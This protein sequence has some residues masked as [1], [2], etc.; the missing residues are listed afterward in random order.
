MSL[1]LVLKCDECAPWLIGRVS[2]I[3]ELIISLWEVVLSCMKTSCRYLALKTLELS[4]CQGQDHY[5]QC[6][7]MTRQQLCNK[8]VSSCLPSEQ[9]SLQEICLL[10]IRSLLLRS[11]NVSGTEQDDSVPAT[12]SIDIRIFRSDSKDFPEA[13]FEECFIEFKKKV[14]TLRLPT[15]FHKQII[16]P[17]L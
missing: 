1:Y 10:E 4:L 14:Q 5:D 7:H 6:T 11:Q 2:K 9:V 17:S 13:E 16:F 3:H 12:V 15:R 8:I